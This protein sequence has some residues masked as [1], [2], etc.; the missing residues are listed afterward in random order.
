M[1]KN[2]GVGMFGI[3][4]KKRAALLILLLLAAF[5]VEAQNG[6]NGKIT[7]KIVDSSTGQPVQYAS[8]SL[9]LQSENKEVNGIT[10][11]EKGA[12]E[13]TNVPEGTYKL[14]AFF[15]GYKTGTWSNIVISKANPKMDLGTIKLASTAAKLK[16]V[17][18][19]T[20]KNTVEYKIDK[21]VYNVD[22]DM[23]S[24]TGVATDVLKKIPEVEVDVDGNVELQGNADIRFLINGKPSTVFG[25]NLADVLQSIPASQIQSIEVIT[26]P[27]A[28]YDAEGTAGII[29][30]ILKKNRAEGIHGNTSLSGGT[31]LENGSFNLDG[32]KGNFGA[33]AYVSGNAQLTSTTINSLNRTGQDTGSTSSQLNQNGTSNFRREGYQTGVGIDWEISSKDNINA[34]FGYN[35]FSNNSVGITNSATILTGPSGNILSDMSDIINGSSNFHQQTVD[36]DIAYKRTFNKKDQE[37]NVLLTTSST[38]NYSYYMQTQQAMANDSIVSSSYANNPGVSKETDISVDYT[39]PV[40]DDILIETGAKT[41]LQDITST[42]NVYLLDPLSD[43]YSY[44]NT[45]SSSLEYKSNIYAGYLSSDFK[46]FKWLNVKTGIR[47]E[48]TNINATYSTSGNVNIQPYGTWVP[49]VAFSHA[50]K[51]NQTLKLTYSRRLQRP[52]YNSLNPFINA[53]DPQNITAGNPALQPEIGDKIEL[54]YNKFL[55][56]GGNINLTLFYRDNTHDIQPYTTYYPA[57]KIGDSTYTNVSLT[58]PENIGHETNIG[59]NIFGSIPVKKKFNIR[60]NLSFYQRYISTGLS[61]GGNISGFNYRLNMNATYQFSKT[62]SAEAFANYNST[63]INAQ[64]TYPAFFTYNFAIRKQLFNEKASLAIT[65][66]NPFNYYVSQTTNLSGQNFALLIGR[67]LP[68]QSFGFNF[69]YKFGK[70]EFKKEKEVE[71]PNLNPPQDN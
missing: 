45:Q 63:R 59:L 50:F 38:N 55:D 11:D 37:L 4:M 58:V 65:A 13:L 28:K 20:D 42:S 31:R 56:K 1:Q 71:D 26:S 27:G 3:F 41:Q 17:T 9:V 68:Y 36:G 48:Y 43:D 2:V 33:H 16:E 61:T 7:G 54:G 62:L 47:Y 30:I 23:T 52:G 12:F 6:A 46:L 19:A 60:T 34:D 18:I 5:G 53:G 40:T 49:S 66:T 44:S 15:I 57:Y 35:Y 64:G 32:R 24:Q 10:T 67:Q 39:Q 25:N 22:K 29:N 8:V 69:T 14:L 51:N 70:L 21:T